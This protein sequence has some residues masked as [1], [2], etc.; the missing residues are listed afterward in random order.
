MRSK[1]GDSCLRMNF[2]I[3]VQHQSYQGIAQHPVKFTDFRANHMSARIG[4]DC[5]NAAGPN[6]QRENIFCEI[7][8]F[9]SNL[10]VLFDPFSS[11]TFEHHATQDPRVRERT[12]SV[13]PAPTVTSFRSTSQLGSS[14]P[15]LL[16]Q[17]D[18]IPVCV[19]PY[20]VQNCLA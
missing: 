15:L 6:S 9:K 1:G 14:H 10:R 16:H 8:S 17:K 3:L 12:I 5:P 2:S 19:L 11:R 18:E 7:E 4:M 20:R 13:S